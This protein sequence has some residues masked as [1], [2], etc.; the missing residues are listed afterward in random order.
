MFPKTNVL[1]SS[2]FIVSHFNCFFDVPFIGRTDKTKLFSNRQA[3]RLGEALVSPTLEFRHQH[4][5]PTTKASERGEF[6]Y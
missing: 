3:I 4:L 1:H 5:T 6:H 2:R